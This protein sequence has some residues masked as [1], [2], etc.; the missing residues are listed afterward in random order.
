MSMQKEIPKG[1]MSVGIVFIL[2]FFIEAI[3]VAALPGMPPYYWA[4]GGTFL[5][6]GIII[7]IYAYRKYKAGDYGKTS[8]SGEATTPSIA[9][10]ISDGKLFRSHL[11]LGIFIIIL[12]SMLFALASGP[13]T[14]RSSRIT[15]IVTGVLL[16]FGAIL[17]LIIYAVKPK[18]LR[19]KYLEKRAKKVAKKGI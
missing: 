4:I 12:A 7:L 9:S 2:L 15:Y 19:Q 6:L 11:I 8:S 3:V 1:I 10:D 5:M 14:V 17:N 16:L 13:F 18:K